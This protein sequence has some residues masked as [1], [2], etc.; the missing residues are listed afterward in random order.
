MRESQVN[1]RVGEWIGP[2]S[3]LSVGDSKKLLH[4]QDFKVGAARPFN[5]LQV[6]RYFKPENIAHFF[7]MGLQCRFQIFGSPLENSLL[8][9]ELIEDDDSRAN[10]QEMA[11]A[12]RNEMKNLLERGSFK[13]FLRKDTCVIWLSERYIVLL[14]VIRQLSVLG[15]AITTLSYFSIEDSCPYEISAYGE[16]P[17]GYPVQDIFIQFTYCDHIAMNY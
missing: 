5:I 10:S 4:V 3:V 12:E 14:Y 6:K 13:I 8:L 16:I 2:L 9:T 17:E 15:V 7:M 1:N 11:K